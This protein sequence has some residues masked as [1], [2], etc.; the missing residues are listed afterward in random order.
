ME[1]KVYIPET[2][3]EDFMRAFLTF[4]FQRVYCPKRQ[5]LVTLHD[6]AESPHGS[7][8]KRIKDVSF[9]GK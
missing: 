8:L 7:E 6:Q 5:K 2:Y 4:K 3:E 9:L 1:P